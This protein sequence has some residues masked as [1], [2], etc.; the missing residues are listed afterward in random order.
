MDLAFPCTL[1]VLLLKFLQE[2][3]NHWGG[4]P[5]RNHRLPGLCLHGP[6]VKP[7]QAFSSTVQSPF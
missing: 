2:C 7:S 6:L 3:S 1:V 5:D 4:L